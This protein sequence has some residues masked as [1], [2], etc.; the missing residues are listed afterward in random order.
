[1]NNARHIRVSIDLQRLALVENNRTLREYVISTSAR[2][3]GFAEGSLRTPTGRF[4]L[5]DKIGHEA[6]SNTIFKG[7]VAA[8]TWQPGKN[9]AEDLILARILRLDGLDPENR[10]TRERFIYIHGTNDTKNLGRPASHGCVRMSPS[11]IIDLFPMVNEGMEVVIEPQTKPKGKLFFIDCDSTL[12]RIEG[13]DELARARGPAVYSKVAEMTRA[14]MH[15]EVGLDEVFAKRLELIRPDKPQREQVAE[16]YIREMVPGAKQLAA[17]LRKDGWTPVILSGGFRQLI[18]PLAREIG[19]DHVEAVPLLLDD[20]GNYLGYDAAHPASHTM[21]KCKVI[22]EWREAMLPTATVMM[23]DGASDLETRECVDA[24]ICYTGVVD[25]PGVSSGAD[26]K[27]H[28]MR[29]IGGILK[30]LNDIIS[31]EINIAS[32][33]DN[34]HDGGDMSSKTAKKAATKTAAKPAADKPAADKPATKKAAVKGKRYTPAEKKEIVDFILEYNAKNGRGGQMRAFE[35]WGVSQITIASWLKKAGKK[36]TAAT[37]KAAA[38]PAKKAAK[39][40]SKKAA[41]KSAA[42]KNVAAVAAGGSLQA[43][44]AKLLELDKAISASEASLAAM[45]K[46][47]AALKASL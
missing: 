2:G 8:G 7:R 36:P 29:K 16:S 22:R 4:R 13:I 41:K 12:S 3:M 37:K 23:G 10:N 40:S 47:F 19:I 45:K 25:R 18:E 5:I 31:N 27:I 44:L 14:A 26:I 39:K 46:E 21:G 43:K 1:M 30:E 33:L 28:D 17:E 6:A 38:K 24:F 20:D 42:K 15:G 11:D 35:K 9:E 34:I 32:S